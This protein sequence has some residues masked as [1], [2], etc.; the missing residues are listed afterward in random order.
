MM[1]CP[2]QAFSVDYLCSPRLVFRL[3]MSV[4]TTSLRS[5]QRRKIFPS[6]Y[7]ARL[8]SM[9]TCHYLY[10][11]TIPFIS[12]GCSVAI[13]VYY[14]LWS[15]FLANRRMQALSTMPFLGCGQAFVGALHQ[16][17]MYFPGRILGGFLVLQKGSTRYTMTY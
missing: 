1:K 4:Q 9:T 15:P 7:N 2:A 14:I 16:V 8:L 5:S 17:G 10:Q 13:A 3:S 11:A 6:Q 12:P